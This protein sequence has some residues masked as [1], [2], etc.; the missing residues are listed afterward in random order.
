MKKTLA[1]TIAAGILAV[2]SLFAATVNDVKVTLTHPA[3]VGSTTL[4]SGN[5][6]LSPMET[7]DGAGF[8]VVR[9]NNVAPVVIPVQKVVGATAPKTEL[10][11]TETGNDWR[12]E[13]L[14][15]EGESTAYAFSGR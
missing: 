8:F 3:T 14:S 10:T 4:P 1:L 6:T 13:K 15:I 9:G 2:G 5:Y 12:I 7:S 11:I